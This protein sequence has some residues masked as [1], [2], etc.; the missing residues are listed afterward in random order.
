MVA[1]RWLPVL[2]LLATVWSQDGLVA[3]NEDTC[4]NCEADHRRLASAMGQ[5]GAYDLRQ[6]VMGT[7]PDLNAAYS[8][9]PF[10]TFAHGSLGTVGP[11]VPNAVD[12][13][14]IG[15]KNKDQLF[16][17][18]A[19]LEI[20]DDGEMNAQIY[21]PDDFTVRD[22]EV[23]VR[24]L[25]HEH[26][27]D[28][29]LRLQHVVEEHSQPDM[30]IPDP[31]V[32]QDLPNVTRNLESLNYA[33]CILV[34]QRQGNKFY[35][36]PDA[37]PHPNI[38]SFS[39]G[40]NY[41]EP[42]LVR[43]L[44]YN[45]VFSDTES[46][47]L[48]LQ[49]PTKQSSTKFGGESSRAVDGTTN[50]H[51]AKLSVTHT[52]GHKTH[53]VTPGNPSRAEDPE[54]WWQV[55]L[56]STQPIG[57]L[58]IWNRI[59]E[60]NVDE[61]QQIRTHSASALAGTFQVSFNFSGVVQTTEPIRWDAVPM[62][63]DEDGNLM[64]GTP[65]GNAPGES[66]QAKLQGVVNINTVLVERTNWV[67]T[68]APNGVNAY[69]WLVTFISEPGDLNQMTVAATQFTS[70]GSFVTIET[71]RNGNSN[72]WYNYKYGMS[73]ISGRLTPS[74]IM[75]LNTDVDDM[76]YTA[77]RDLA[78][79]KQRITVD[80][81][82]IAFQMPSI[83]NGRYIRVQLES[84]EP[85][86][87]LSI[88][89]LQAYATQ[90]NEVRY[91]R[92]GSPIMAD[93]YHSE[94]S[95]RENFGGIRARGL[96]VLSLRDY[97]RRRTVNTHDSR[98]PYDIHGRG[99]IDDWTLTITDTR[100]QTRVYYMDIAAVV[101]TLP[102]YGRLFV[103]NEEWRARGRQIGFVKGQG[104]HLAQCYGNCKDNFQVGNRL[105]TLIAGSMA[106]MNF[107]PNNRYVVYAPNRD[108]LG[109]DTFSYTITTGAQESETTGVVVMDTRVCRN[110]NCLNEAF[111][112]GNYYLQNL[113]Y[114]KSLQPLLSSQRGVRQAELLRTMRPSG[115]R[116]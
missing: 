30:G 27:G 115:S 32:T 45:Y 67:A 116:L 86:A 61:V 28:L 60:D 106:D 63:Q 41:Q 68:T 91:Y 6:G 102:T 12:Y 99:A 52:A 54:P 17:L 69:Q 23:N 56:G 58:R 104:E 21:V 50:G 101:K 112:D 114:R 83:V 59:Q 105:S 75:I 78:V 43:G 92:G 98:A 96:W 80:A 70:Q 34:D 15:D 53:Q 49:K 77:A 57:S 40:A 93:T 72:V 94:E 5:A 71:V 14:I 73:L 26:A 76:N 10:A 13:T 82:E 35:G 111:A 46:P 9:G 44:G 103:Y 84:R 64:A 51:Y 37:H 97:K 79:W 18:R 11:P 113:W 55:D 29:R 47:N 110:S 108:F 19:N 8:G 20:P 2:L 24:G 1:L 74:W 7:V 36:T 66:M 42:N 3:G 107:I 25:Y 48:A 65:A 89:E 90:T 100:N 109:E 39:P 38:P 85:D 4:Y 22:I 62:I 33:E 31:N 87:Y 81:R 95:L 16:H 88:A